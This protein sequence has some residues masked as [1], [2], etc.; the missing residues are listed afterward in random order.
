M[1]ITWG[2]LGKLLLAGLGTYVMLPAVLI[3]RDYILWKFIKAYIL[4]DKLRQ[5]VKA[6]AVFVHGWNKDFA[7]D[8]KI[9]SKDGEAT[10]VV[11]E[12]ELSLD[13][14]KLYRQKADKMEKQIEETKLFINRKSNFLNW[15]LK[16]Y[17]QDATNPIDEWFKSDTKRLIEKNV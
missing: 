3:L 15:L 5:K 17:K 8:V 9:T 4:N 12:K 13:E 14:F 11:G 16:H 6:H 7:Y 10:Y 2:A 1:D